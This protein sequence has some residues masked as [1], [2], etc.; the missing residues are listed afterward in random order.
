MGR[1]WS[2]PRATPEQLGHPCRRGPRRGRGSTSATTPSSPAR[3][4][5]SRAGGRAGVVRR[6]QLRRRD[7]A[8]RPVQARRH[9][10]VGCDKGRDHA[11]AARSPRRCVEATASTGRRPPPATR[12]KRSRAPSSR[13]S[14]CDVQGYDTW[15]WENKALFRAAR[16]LYDDIGW[17]ATGDD[18][19][20]PWLIDARYGTS[21]R[22]SAPARGGKN[23]GF[24]DW[25][26]GS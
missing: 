5:S 6:L 15:N 19:W 12:G 25:L 9:R 10:P 20:Q 21:F 3:P 11:S 14:S 16:F 26:Y 22:G 17:A 7:L 13:P 23:F 24:T 18:E 2:D 8:V 1:P 4:P